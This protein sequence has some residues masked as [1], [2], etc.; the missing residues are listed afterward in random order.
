[1]DTPDTSGPDVPG[2]ETS[3][4]VTAPED[5]GRDVDSPTDT[6]GQDGTAAEI[7]TA[8][9]NGSACQLNATCAGGTCLDWPT[10]YCSQIDCKTSGC[11]GD[12]VCVD[13]AAGNSVCLGECES[14]ADCRAPHQ[15]CKTLFASDG[16]VSVCVGIEPQAVGPGAA[17]TD[18]ARCLAEA[19]CLPSFPGGYCAE[20]GCTPGSCPAETTCVKVDGTPS[21]LRSCFEDND[22]DGEAGAERK[23]GVLAGLTG[24][25]Q[26]VCI[27][28]ITARGVGEGCVSDFECTSGSCQI[29]GEG[30]CNVSQVPCFPESAAA[31]C[32][33]GDY[34]RITAVSRVGVC[35]QACSAGV[36]C[37][38]ANFCLAEGQ[39][40]RS[41][42]CR[43]TCGSGDGQCNAAAGLDCHFGLPLSDSGQGRY[44][45]AATVLGG[46]FFPCNGDAACPGGRCIKPAG[47]N[48]QGYCVRG[49]GDD[50]YCGFGGSCVRGAPSG[51]EC[52]RMCFASTDCPTGFR[53]GT[54]T[55]SV[56][57]VCI[58]L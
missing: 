35:S 33:T 12:G 56:R 7:V 53:C 41:T 45:C 52:W 23:C 19:A 48:A 21:C 8:G 20:I 16:T 37:A 44:V 22:C 24:D 27:S 11:G 30:R 10:G 2:Q 34:C 17:C 58:P 46:P 5:G 6:G 55:G 14:S 36:T 25:P 32:G 43:P 9:G 29:L 40:A 42:W 26:R 51:N 3:D 4:D 57:D 39:A 47:N 1:L 49:C 50:D 18:P 31:T 54:A 13:V 15:A 38:G 28:G